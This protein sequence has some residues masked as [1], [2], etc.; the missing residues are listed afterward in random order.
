MKLTDKQ[1]ALLDGANYAVVAVN[2]DRGRPRSTVVWVDRDGDTVRFNT[3]SV[4]AKGRH[5]AHGGFVSVLVVD[6]GDFHRWLE[7][8]GPAEVSAEGADEHINALSHKYTGKDFANPTNRVIVRVT[9]ERVNEY[10]L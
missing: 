5:L 6:G 8:Q 1:R 4:R 7:V 9:P 2:D 10:D 3:T